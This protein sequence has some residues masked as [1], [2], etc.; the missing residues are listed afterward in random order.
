M[1]TTD[2]KF[3]EV[4]NLASQIEPGDDKVHFRAIYGNEHG[5]ASLLAFKGGQALAKHMAP[6]E[7][8]VNVIEGEVVFHLAVGDRTLRAGDFMLVGEG[9]EHSVTA[10]VDSKVM[11]VKVK[12]DK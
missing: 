3:A 8:M 4:H 12:S 7:V 1:I 5:G 6:A 11:L 2:Y 9:V 10:T